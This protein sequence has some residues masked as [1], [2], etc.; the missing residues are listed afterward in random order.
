[1]TCY[2]DVSGACRF[3]PHGSRN[4]YAPLTSLTSL[5]RSTFQRTDGGK[6]C[7]VV[8]RVQG[9]E[10]PSFRT[11]LCIQPMTC[12]HWLP[13]RYLTGHL[14]RRLC[15]VYWATVRRL[16]GDCGTT[17][18]DCGTIVGRLWDDCGM[19]VGRLWDDCALSER[20]LHPVAKENKFLRPQ[21]AG[22]LFAWSNVCWSDSQQ[23]RALIQLKT[24][25][26]Y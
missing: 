15:G 21:R 23:R 4:R 13:S 9:F 2:K 20:G 1:M 11:G 19:T 14:V 18:G 12:L 8:D 5:R 17:A 7:F 25:F 22:V 3:E 16:C 10:R 6:T 24:G 26:T